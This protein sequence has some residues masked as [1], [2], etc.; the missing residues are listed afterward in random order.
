MTHAHC[1]AYGELLLR[2]TP[3]VH[4]ELLEQSD[5]LKMAFAGAEANIICDLSRL[6]HDCAFLSAFPQNPLGRKALSFLNSYGVNTNPVSW[7]A[8]RMGTYYIEHGQSIRGTKVVYDRKHSSVSQTAIS[9]KE[10]ERLLKHQDYFILTGITPALSKVCRD[11]ISAALEV[12][13][14]LPVQVVLDFNYRRSLWSPQDARASLEQYLPKVDLLFANIGAVQD[15][16]GLQTKPWNT[17]KGLE[18][19]SQQALLFLDDL[20]DFAHISLTMRLQHNASENRLSA[21]TK[22]GDQVQWAPWIDTTII[23]RLG[24]GDAF[25][26]AYLH[27]LTRQWPIAQ[28]LAFAVAAFA[29]TQ[30]IIGDINLASEEELLSIAA[31]NTF[32]FAKR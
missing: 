13:Q 22:T 26:A 5:H 12:A 9:A 14:K 10:W 18:E 21:L 7:S 19:A 8:G 24:G 29:Y 27:G 25:V 1:L 4:G 16:F 23:D 28:T 32:G 3:S 11:N 30:T 31:G 15:I 2:L 20:H 6:G 17:Q